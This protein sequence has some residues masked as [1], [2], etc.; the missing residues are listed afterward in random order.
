V[1]KLLLEG[2]VGIVAGAIVV[3]VVTLVQRLRRK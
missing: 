1:V 2:V 3:A